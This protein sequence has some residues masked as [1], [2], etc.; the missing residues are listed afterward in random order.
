MTRTT[1][2]SITYINYFLDLIETRGHEY[3]LT[4][5]EQQRLH[6]LTKNFTKLKIKIDCVVELKQGSQGVRH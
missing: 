5:K 2:A 6:E 3:L 1:L 4:G